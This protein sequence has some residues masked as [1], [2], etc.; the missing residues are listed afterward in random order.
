MQMEVY[1]MTVVL[2]FFLFNAGTLSKHII[3]SKGRSD[4]GSILENRR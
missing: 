4:T 3:G 1:P 2:L